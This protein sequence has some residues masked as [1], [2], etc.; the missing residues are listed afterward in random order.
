M[1]TDKGESGASHMGD[2]M[3]KAKMETNV[4]LKGDFSPMERICLTA[5]GN[6]Q[7]ILRSYHLTEALTSMH[8]LQSKLF[9]IIGSKRL[10]KKSSWTG[11]LKC[12]ASTK[13]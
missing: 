1:T 10:T 9:T 6:L 11:A 12:G 5:N 3:S 2:I 7:R 8:L 4:N 13:Y